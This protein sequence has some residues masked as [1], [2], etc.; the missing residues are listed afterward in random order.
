[1]ERY[2]VVIVGGGVI[3]SAIAYFL[4]KLGRKALIL[5]RERMASQASGAAAGMLGAQIEMGL[6]TGPLFQLARFSRSLFPELSTELRELSGVDIGL[7]Q[8]GTLRTVY[9][10]TEVAHFQDMI[11]RQHEAGEKAEW[12][13]AG[14]L[15]A[16][17]PNLRE[18]AYGAVYIPQDGHVVAPELTKAFALSAVR[19]GAEIRE[20]VEVS[21]LMLK[22]YQVQG[23]LTSAG[24]ISCNHV[25]LCAGAWS[26]RLAAQLGFNL[27]VYPVKGECFSVV[28]ARPLLTSTVFSDDCY[29]VPKPGL[30]TIIGATVKPGSFNRQVTLA[31]IDQLLQSAKQVLPS[32]VD[33]EWEKAWA[34]IRPQTADGLPYLGAHPDWQG[35]TFATGHYRNGILLSP[36]TGMMI[37]DVVNGVATTGVDIHPFAPN[38]TV[39][40]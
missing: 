3:G 7:T 31:G 28:S 33:A 21:S 10:D 14:E 12:L 20:F 9:R 39:Q 1:M 26:G 4:A 23:V 37:A 24:P 16:R 30:R 40:V 36:A 13:T 19:L 35:L 38:R 2:D 6:D 8:K 15:A 25:I 32:I 29:I 17:E 5:E 18:G 27:G 11:K 22:D 34:G